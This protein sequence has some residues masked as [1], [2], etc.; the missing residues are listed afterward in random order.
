MMWGEKLMIKIY[1]YDD[2]IKEMVMNF[3]LGD[4]YEKLCNFDN[5]LW[6]DLYDVYG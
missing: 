6:I 5:L 1:L 3:D 2:E 4:V